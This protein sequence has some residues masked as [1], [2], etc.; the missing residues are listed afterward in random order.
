MEKQYF[1]HKIAI[2][3]AG[4]SG[5][6]V[7]NLLKERYDVTLFEKETNPGGLIRCRREADGSL[8]HIC[9]GHV[10]NT[11]HSHV[12][13]WFWSHF[14]C[15][16]E[17]VKADRN[18][19]VFMPDGK[20][21]PYPIENHVYK[22]DKQTQL[23]F[24]QD[25]LNMSQEHISDNFEDFLITRFGTTLYKLYFQPY[26]TKVWRRPLNTIPLS[27][28][29][30]KLPMPTVTEMIYNNFNHIEEKDFVH[31]TFYYEKQDGSQFIANR[32]A[33]KLHIHYNQYIEKIQYIKGKWQVQ[34]EIFD[35]IVF[36][37]NIKQLPNLLNGMECISKYAG[38]IEKL[39]F[40]GTT[41]VFCKIDCNPY[42][43][44]YLPNMEYQSHRI[45]CTGNFAASN[46]AGNNLTGTIE[47]TDYMSLD[48]IL[49][50]LKQIPLHPQYIDHHYS[51]Y[52]YPIQNVD[53]RNIV[54]NLKTELSKMGFYMTGRFADW[55]YYNMDAAIEAAMKV[56]GNI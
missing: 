26:N 30:G 51:Q 42:S 24:I 54:K 29:E 18:S 41:S 8:F 7:A 55:E 19:I 4:I 1:D 45:I 6:T 25:L 37:G 22:L 49:N 3:G 20:E 34:G 47:F 12:L 27:W 5:L 32:L 52:T 16:K 39:E 38:S 56:C 36:C 14:D 10:F 2:I 11:K 35:K 17:F 15:N 13:N 46:N 53:T 9:G 43:W 50:Q 33:E 21:I 23:Q 44:I 40:H 48:D 31:S 28:L